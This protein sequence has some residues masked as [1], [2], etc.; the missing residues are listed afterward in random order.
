MK[1]KIK[2]RLEGVIKLTKASGP[3]IQEIFNLYKELMNSKFVGCSSCPSSVR[4]AHTNI[5]QYYQTHYGK[6]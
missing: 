1:D 3:Q 4:Q 5:K 2:E 6:K